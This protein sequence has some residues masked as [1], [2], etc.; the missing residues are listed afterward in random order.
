MS[1]LLALVLFML[2]KVQEYSISY[3]SRHR[4]WYEVNKKKGEMLEVRKKSL[5]GL[6]TLTAL[7]SMSLGFL[8]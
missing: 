3:V 4:I 1:L 8:R 7:N 2:A 6:V 5:P